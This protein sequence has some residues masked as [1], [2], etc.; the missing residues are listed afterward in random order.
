V[1]APL[2]AIPS[3]VMF[4]SVSGPSAVRQ[5]RIETD[6]PELAAKYVSAS[7]PDYLKI[8]LVNQD[9]S[10]LLFNVQLLPETPRGTL[11]GIISLKFDIPELPQLNVSVSGQ[12]TGLLRA[13]PAKLVVNGQGG[14]QTLKLLI[15]STNGQKFRLLSGSTPG[16]ATPIWKETKDPQ[17]RYLIDVL[18]TE[19]E[20]LDGKTITI[21][22]DML[23]EP[24][25]HIPISV[26]ATR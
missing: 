13:V 11:K 5:L 6:P 2:R 24:S 25:I 26:M 16:G 22:T 10:G 7:A 19:P 17:E 1:R 21:N 8:Q 14:E 15:A 18:F 23:E 12:K 20:E 3:E 4:G 9:R